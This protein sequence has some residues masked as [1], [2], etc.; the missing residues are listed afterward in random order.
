MWG[1]P[2]DYPYFSFDF[3]YCPIYEY[4]Y[5]VYGWGSRPLSSFPTGGVGDPSEFPYISFD[6]LNC[7]IHEYIWLRGGD[8]GN[9]DMNE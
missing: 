4:N 3:L 2:R 8:K 5:M 9:K 7:P 6:L 1:D